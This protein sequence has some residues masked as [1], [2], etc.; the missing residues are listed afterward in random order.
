MADNEITNIGVMSGKPYGTAPLS[1][2]MQ[3]LE[4]YTS[5]AL[6]RKFK[7]IV[8]P[9][10]YLGFAP[11]AGT[12][13]NVVVTSNEAPGGQGAAS[14]DV[15]AHQI[16]IQHL[17]DLTLPVVAGK[18]TRIV[19]EANYKLGTK[20]DQ[21][22]ITSTVKAAQVIAQDLAVAMTDNQLELCRVIVP[23]GATQ[24]TQAMIVTTWRINRQVGL[25][26]DS[27]Y[28]SDDE[29]I[30]ANLKGL[31]ILKG[32][33]DTKME[34]DKNG[35]DIKDAEAFRK[36]IGLDHLR[37]DDN[38]ALIFTGSDGLKVAGAGDFTSDG[39]VLQ[40]RQ[41]TAD[42]SYLL[43]GKK[44]DD[45][46]H[47]YIGQADDSTDAVTWGNSIPNTWM[48]LAADG[49]GVSNV[50]KMTFQGDVAANGGLTVSNGANL[51]GP[52]NVY[53]KGS[54]GVGDL[55]SAALYVCGN[56]TDGT[57][58]I[59]VSS[60]APNL[61]FIDRSSDS[62]GFRWRGDSNYLR[63]D[64]D[65]RDSGVTWNQNLALFSDKGH[66]SVGGG[67]G[68]NGRILTLGDN[69]AGN[70]N[71]IGAS[72]IVAMAY[73]N[74]GAD[75]TTRGIGFGAEM[76]VGDGTTAQTMPDWVE[77]W[78]NSSVVNTNAAVTLMTSFR[79]YDKASSSIA[80]AYAFD[81]RQS[82]RDGVSRWNLY[83]QGTAP[84]YMRGQTIIGGT[85]TKLP[86]SSFA[87][88]VRGGAE[89]SDMFISRGFA[90]FRSQVSLVSATPYIDFNSSTAQLNDYDA[91]IIVDSTTATTN[92]QAVMTIAA[93][94]LN[95][96]AASRIKGQLIIDKDAHFDDAVYIRGSLFTTAHMSIG[97]SGTGAFAG[98][99]ASLNIG[100][101][102]TG[103]V[104]PGDGILDVYANNTLT[105]RYTPNK[106]YV[107]GKI[108][109]EDADGFR[110]RPAAGKIGMIHR[111]DGS[112]YYML[113][114]NENDQ[115]G[116]WNTLRPFQFNGNSGAVTMSHNVSIG[117]GLSVAGMF[118]VGQNLSVS[119]TGWF[120]NNVSVQWGGRGVTY[121]ENGDIVR[122]GNV[123]DGYTI[124][125]NFGSNTSLSGALSW[126]RNQ[127]YNEM[128][129][130]AMSD[131]GRG[132]QQYSAGS[133]TGSGRAYEVPAGCVLTGINTNVSDGRGMGVYFR[134][135]I[136]RKINGGQFGVGDFA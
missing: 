55:T 127:G 57:Q 68:N 114:T 77:F 112:N 84:N 60:F 22:D 124:F 102:D 89:V 74:I 21:V 7:G 16:T 6:N 104:C 37:T 64:V 91:R 78:G 33:I 46:L 120:G 130:N 90:E 26:L 88:S 3:Y 45:T 132:G 48:T 40:V 93:S 59:T 110:I 95:I 108:V 73:A 100:D 34:I 134:Q 105:A 20:T 4:T 98:T 126:V 8:L 111:F 50:L 49:T 36:N 72:Q 11:V 12:G 129:N 24:V 63:L 19:L 47:W 25:T 136:G 53:A 71:L 131:F 117:G 42:K 97:N 35:A 80:T 125:S 92:G 30:A 135:L 32:L 27:I 115:D 118:S 123:T 13:L 43:R 96:N 54:V 66:L 62:A 18:T 99:S 83:M 106:L 81:G 41:K 119:G 79:S 28:T 17:A 75:A 23:A 109:S 86:G 128:V 2:D 31:K 107:Y 14:I 61:A 113:V 85:D 101:S 87:L 15:N 133:G 58:G 76:T 103:L 82:A 67:G 56:S 122:M 38:G 10:F 69:T 39:N 65:N 121:Q 5:S 52:V 44:A 70:R 9:G 1:A 116:S 29:L 94:Q 51:T